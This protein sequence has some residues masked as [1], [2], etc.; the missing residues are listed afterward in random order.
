MIYLYWEPQCLYMSECND[1]TTQPG[2]CVWT[3]RNRHKSWGLCMRTTTVWGQQQLF[4][5]CSLFSHVQIMAVSPQPL[6]LILGVGVVTQAS[7]W[8]QPQSVPCSGQGWSFWS[9]VNYKSDI[10]FPLTWL[11]KTRFVGITS[12]RFCNIFQLFIAW[13]Q[14][15]PSAPDTG[16]N[17]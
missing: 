2:L 5:A 17:Q 10:S 12:P 8:W 6:P 4:A 1:C 15:E 13:A 16:A 3:R 9:F 14:L 7:S 11:F